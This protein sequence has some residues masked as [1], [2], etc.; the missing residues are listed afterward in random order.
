YY[1]LAEGIG[2]SEFT[3]CELGAGTGYFLKG[4]VING[5]VYGDTL[6]TSVNQIGNSIP[7]N[8]SL[9]QNYPNPFNP[10]TIIRYSIP[11][12]VKGQTLASQSGSDVKLTVHD[13]LGN[14]VTTLV[15]EKQ[16]AGSYEL[17]FDGAGI[18]SG[19]YFYKLEADD[20][21]ETRKM[22]LLK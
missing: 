8:F 16:N 6:L 18:P 19:I 15:N 9:S 13:A 1:K 5:I 12:N 7:A 20:F 10:K 21:I 4:C 17:E 2:F 22:I 3:S 11:S 14:E